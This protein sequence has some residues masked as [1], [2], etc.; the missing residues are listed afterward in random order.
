MIWL[1]EYSPLIQPV[2]LVLGC[3]LTIAPV[4]KLICIG[5]RQT[6]PRMNSLGDDT[7][8]KFKFL[9]TGVMEGGR[10]LS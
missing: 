6:A 8:L 1:F 3:C 2:W 4:D 9:N 5:S 10:D 7:L